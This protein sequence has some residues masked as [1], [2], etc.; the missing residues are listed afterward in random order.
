[1]S[2]DAFLEVLAGCTDAC[3]NMDL[4][5]DGWMPPDGSFDVMVES[6][7]S[8]LKEKNG[9]NN[10]WI[11]PVFTILDGEF[12]GRSFSDYYW[13]T[14]G[15]AE[16]SISIKNLCRFATCLQGS[17]T[18]QPIEAS[19]IAKA[20]VGEFLNVEVYRTTSRKTG[21]T[22]PNVRFCQ[23]LEATETTETTEG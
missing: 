16:P 15:M 21:K 6:V 11:K 13:I 3:A 12:K 14:P 1:M 2:D 8:G 22:Y 20:S 17:E 9:V 19:E 5:D 18:K 7:G 10:A 4:T 23:R